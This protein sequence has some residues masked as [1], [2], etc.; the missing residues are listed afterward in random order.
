MCL[1]PTGEVV[2]R[3]ELQPHKTIRHSRCE[4][5]V[6]GGKRCS[7]CESHRKTL[8]VLVGHRVKVTPCL[9]TALGNQTNYRYLTTPENVEY[10]HDMQKHQHSLKKQL[11]RFKSRLQ[12]V[13][14][15][16]GVQVDESL[17]SDLQQIARER[18][19]ARFP[20]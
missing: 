15:H 7:F 5:L 12:E 11:A 16:E 3:T 17:H 18:A 8:P 14:A 2:A 4:F 13:I 19:R 1:S 10:L 20:Q 6:G 9:K